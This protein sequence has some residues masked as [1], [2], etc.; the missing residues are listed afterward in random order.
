MRPPSRSD[1]VLAVGLTAVAAVVFARPLASAVSAL[2]DLERT[3][4]VAVLPGL[5][6]ASILI[7]WYYLLGRLKAQRRAIDAAA[8][9]ARAQ[10]RSRELERLLDFWLALFEAL[11][12]EAI[13]EVLPRLLDGIAGRAGVWVLVREGGRWES[14]LG[15]REAGRGTVSHEDLATETMAAIGDSPARDGHAVGGHLVFPMVA[16]GTVVGVIGVPDEDG[17]MDLERRHMV[18]AAA[19]HDGVRVGTRDGVRDGCGAARERVHLEHPHRSVP[20]YRLGV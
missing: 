9:A 8:T 12:L 10:D 2:G 3:S 18:G 1:L 17:R 7:A 11:D 13:R 19:A 6:L 20:E 4:G 16:V 15:G 5:A 14:M